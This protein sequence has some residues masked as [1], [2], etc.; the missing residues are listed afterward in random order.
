VL[1]DRY[2]LVYTLGGGGMGSVWLAEDTLLQRSVA[3]AA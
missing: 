3:G 1:S 2:R